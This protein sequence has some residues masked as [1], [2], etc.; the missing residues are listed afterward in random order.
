MI[1]RHPFYIHT[2]SA[3]LGLGP[4]QGSIWA[5]TRIHALGVLKIAGFAGTIHGNNWGWETGAKAY[6]RSTAVEA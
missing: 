3:R 1:I 4:P 2:R 5:A 6:T